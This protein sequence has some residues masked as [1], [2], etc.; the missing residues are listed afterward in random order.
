[1]RVEI[2]R[3]SAGY[4]RRRVI[5]DVSLT[6]DDGACVFILGPNGSGKTTLFRAI[7]GLIAATSGQGRVDGE[8]VADWPRARWARAFGYVPQSSGSAC[9]FSV[10]DAV[11]MGRTATMAIWAAPTKAD[12]AAAETT[13]ERLGIASLADRSVAALSGGERQL[14]MMARAL[15]QG[16]SVLV[17]D[18]PTSNLDLAN[19][20]RVVRQI[21]ALSAEGVSVIMTSHLPGQASL[22][23]TKVAAMNAGRLSVLGSVAHAMDEHV[24]RQIY[25]VTVHVIRGTSE[26]GEALCACVPSLL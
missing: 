2:D 24:L 9:P 21:R 7:L 25:G 16:A 5:E 19:Q 8:C 13:L 23:A 4:G 14:V 20:V 18:E 10:I 6:I 22:C 12:Y 1:M 15:A 17:L 11:V 3:V 26:R